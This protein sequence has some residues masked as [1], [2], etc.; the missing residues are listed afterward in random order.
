MFDRVERTDEEDTG[1][2]I[3]ITEE[4]RERA[5]KVRSESGVTDAARAMVR[6]TLGLVD[7]G[8]FTVF[9]EDSM[10]LSLFMLFLWHSSCSVHWCYGVRLYCIA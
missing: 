3:W 1:K 5:S 8:V 10:R 4:E 9:I 6:I 2:K 7:Y